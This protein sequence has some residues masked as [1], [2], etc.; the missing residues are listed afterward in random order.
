MDALSPATNHAMVR[1]DPHRLMPAEDGTV[2]ADLF[3]L[4]ARL[5][6]QRMGYHHAHVNARGEQFYADHQLLQRLY[7]GDGTVDPV[8]DIDQLM[9]HLAALVP[10]RLLD[11][12]AMG[13]LMN[14]YLDHYRRRAPEE[15]MRVALGLEREIS[16]HVDRLIQ[17]NPD[18]SGGLAN[19]LQ[20]IADHRQV[21]IY[22]LQQRLAGPQGTTTAGPSLRGRVPI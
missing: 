3:D 15:A 12:A 1:A 6:A 21:A 22:L 2:A 20:Q 10:G 17:S 19:T 4:I 13:E 14:R 18:L 9:E 5:S 11:P 8:E 16:A 7:K